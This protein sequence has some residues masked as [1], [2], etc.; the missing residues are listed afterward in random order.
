MFLV[1]WRL[2]S[3]V[4]WRGKVVIRRHNL[5]LAEQCLLMNV[6]CSTGSKFTKFMQKLIDCLI[7]AKRWNLNFAA[8]RQ[9]FLLSL[10]R[11]FA[12]YRKTESNIREN[13]IISQTLTPT[14]KLSRWH[15]TFSLWITNLLQL[16]SQ[17]TCIARPARPRTEITYIPKTLAS[18]MKLQSL[19]I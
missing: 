6:A 19:T 14:S 7:Y 5:C 18:W 3:R 9:T 10:E 11:L 12:W 13:R 16:S 15:G 17:E 1:A 2:Q 4:L 8:W